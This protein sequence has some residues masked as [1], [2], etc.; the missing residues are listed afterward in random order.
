MDQPRSTPNDVYQVNYAVNVAAALLRHSRCRQIKPLTG[1]AVLSSA[2]LKTRCFI[3]SPSR[4]SLHQN[5][6]P[7]RIFTMASGELFPHEISGWLG[8][9]GRVFLGGNIALTMPS[10]LALNAIAVV[11]AIFLFCTKC[12]IINRKTAS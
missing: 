4:Q 10:V 12:K 2:T 1:L 11:V 8:W 6:D 7:R 3:V 5:V 9:L